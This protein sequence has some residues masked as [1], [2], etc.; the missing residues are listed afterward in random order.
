MPAPR[1]VVK[2]DDDDD[3]ASAAKKPVQYW[4]RTAKPSAEAIEKHWKSAAGAGYLDAN[5]IHSL[6]LI[7]HAE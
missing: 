6:F 3:D 2:K 5:G 7:Q 4:D 1:R